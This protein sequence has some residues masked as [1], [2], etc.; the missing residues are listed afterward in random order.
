MASARALFRTLKTTGQIRAELA[1]T[2]LSNSQNKFTD[3]R[4][5]LS[6]MITVPIA[7]AAITALIVTG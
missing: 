7:L 3:T 2:A 1:V 5:Q 6:W 4:I